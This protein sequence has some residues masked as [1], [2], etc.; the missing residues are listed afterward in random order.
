[1]AAKDWTAG[2]DPDFFKDM[3]DAL[4]QMIQTAEAISGAG[5][6]APATLS[7][8]GGE[9]IVMRTAD[10]QRH[11]AA[12]AAAG[13][14]ADGQYADWHRRL[15]AGG[16]DFLKTVADLLQEMLVEKGQPMVGLVASDG[17]RMLVTDEANLD[18]GTPPATPA[19]H[20]N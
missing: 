7:S 8:P 3:G 15:N 10:F 13:P 14:P 6:V 1:M 17:R 18:A 16:P 19:R 5:G 2:D 9:L 11:L 20:L 12:A 4:D